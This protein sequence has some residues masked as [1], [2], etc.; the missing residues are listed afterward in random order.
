MRA[1]IVRG[2]EFAPGQVIQRNLSIADTHADHPI[3]R[4]V[5]LRGNSHP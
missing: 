5:L 2:A 1:D 4:D 3:F